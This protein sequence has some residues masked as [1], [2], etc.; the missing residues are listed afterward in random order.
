MAVVASE[1]LLKSLLLRHFPFREA[2]FVFA[3][4]SGV[5]AQGG[6]VS[7]GKV[8]A[9]ITFHHNLGPFNIY[10]FTCFYCNV[11]YYEH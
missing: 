1:T 3:Y 5:F 7:K 6:G 10:F 9:I 2:N 4:G 8:G 11:H